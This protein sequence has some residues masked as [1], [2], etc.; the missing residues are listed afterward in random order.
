MQGGRS[1]GEWVL[2]LFSFIVG[3]GLVEN[4]VNNFCLAYFIPFIDLKTKQNKT[5]TAAWVAEDTKPN[6]LRSSLILAVS[7]GGSLVP[8]SAG[9]PTLLC[10]SVWALTR[11]LFSVQSSSMKCGNL[12]TLGTAHYVKLDWKWLANFVVGKGLINRD[13]RS[14]IIFTLF[15]DKIKLNDLSIF[16]S[17]YNDSKYN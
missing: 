15:I 3:S 12:I 14:K 2:F 6:L 1:G 16:S 5:K 17:P 4:I 7:N 9:K 10:F 13:M 8:G 11:S